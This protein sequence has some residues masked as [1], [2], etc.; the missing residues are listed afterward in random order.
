ML[1][2]LLAQGAQQLQHLADARIG[3]PVDDLAAAALRN[4]QAAP[5]QAGQMVRDAA[6]R[7]IHDRHQL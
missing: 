4:G 1:A 5:L 2:V 7:R 6:L 3:D